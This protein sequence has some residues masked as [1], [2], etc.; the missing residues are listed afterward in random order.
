MTPFRCCN[1]IATKAY[2]EHRDRSALAHADKI[3]P[4]AIGQT[5]LRLRRGIEA[6]GAG[7]STPL[8]KA[9]LDTP[10]TASP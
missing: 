2:V 7:A 8:A 1:H 6:I 3:V 4:P 5:R 9:A 10:A